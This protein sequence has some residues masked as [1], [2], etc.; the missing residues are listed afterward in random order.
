M[1]YNGLNRG[2]GGGLSHYK[3]ALKCVHTILSI[4][5]QIVWTH[6]PDLFSF[7]LWNIRFY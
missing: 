1:L 4:F 5:L 2:A 6:G 7:G 3:H